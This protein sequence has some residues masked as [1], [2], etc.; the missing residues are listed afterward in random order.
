MFVSS[1]QTLSSSNTLIELD[2]R[3]K[4]LVIKYVFWGFYSFFLRV[5]SKYLQNVGTPCKST[6]RRN[7]ALQHLYLYCRESLTSHSM[8]PDW[9]LTFHEG[10]SMD[11]GL[12]DCD[13]MMSCMYL[14]SEGTYCLHLVHIWCSIKTDITINKNSTAGD[15]FLGYEAAK[16]CRDFHCYMRSLLTTVITEWNVSLLLRDYTAQYPSNLSSYKPPWEP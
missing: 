4:Y 2:S 16:L 12:L 11:C 1:W 7:P 14:Y 6:L 5:S 8:L 9:C 3:Q 13:V 10:K 15:K